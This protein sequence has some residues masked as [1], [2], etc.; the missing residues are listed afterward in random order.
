MVQYLG[1]D[2]EYEQNRSRTVSAL[3]DPV[4]KMPGNT[5]EDIDRKIKELN[6]L[7]NTHPYVYVVRYVKNLEEEKEHLIREEAARRLIVSAQELPETSFDEVEQVIYLLQFGTGLST[8][9]GD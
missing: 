9:H 8:G 2:K 3:L 5:V 6:S 1:I 7:S 4:L